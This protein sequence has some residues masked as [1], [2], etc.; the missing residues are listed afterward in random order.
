M[1]LSPVGEYLRLVLMRRLSQGPATVGELD[2]LARRAVEGLGVKYDWRVW[3]KLLEGEVA[4][5]GDTVELTKEGRWLFE[6][7]KDVVARYV[8]KALRLKPS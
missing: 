3:P 7:T 8:E 6:Q 1:R 4:V 2:E 5:R